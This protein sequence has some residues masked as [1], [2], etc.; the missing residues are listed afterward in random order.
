[1][2]SINYFRYSIST[3]SLSLGTSV[4]VSCHVDVPQLQHL[5]FFNCSVFFRCEDGYLATCQHLGS[6]EIPPEY[7]CERK[8]VE[9]VCETVHL[10][11]ET[12]P[13][14]INKASDVNRALESIGAQFSAW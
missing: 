14:K 11:G 12:R 1:M 4:P 5:P 2:E 6:P 10:K 13:M 8:E 9:G 7:L 3:G